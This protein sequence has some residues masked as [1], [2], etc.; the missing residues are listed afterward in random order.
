[1]L[2]VAA[3]PAA[4]RC[5]SAAS[6][7]ASGLRRAIAAGAGTEVKDLMDAMRFE[8]HTSHITK[9]RKHKKAPNKET[10]RRGR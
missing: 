7:G 1:M 5:Q 10:R 4:R 6:S 8:K 3:G 9:L 2:Y